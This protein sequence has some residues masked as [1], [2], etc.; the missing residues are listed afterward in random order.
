MT[1][2]SLCYINFKIA[3]QSEI[4]NE[5]IIKFDII[6]AKFIQRM[7]KA[8]SSKPH[9]VMTILVI[10]NK[11]HKQTSLQIIANEFSPTLQ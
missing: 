5:N 9:K 7:C 3:H 10:L 2:V 6:P 4:M 1:K 11:I 8:C